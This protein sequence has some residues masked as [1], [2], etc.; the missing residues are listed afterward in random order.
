MHRQIAGKLTGRVTKWLVLA[1]WVIVVA[2]AGPL[3][4]KLTDVQD[5]QASSWLPASAESTK[6][7][8]KLAPFQDQN[9]IPTVVVYHKASGLTRADLTTIGTQLDQIQQIDG[10]IPAKAPDGTPVQPSQTV[11]V[12]QDG[13]VA[14]GMVTFNFGKDGWN[15]LPDVKDQIT[16]IATLD[17]ADVYVAGPGGQAADSAAVFAGIDGKLLY[18]TVIVV[19]VILLLTYRSPLLW[20]LPVISAGVA[21]TTAQ[22]VIYLLAKNAGLTVNG[23]SAGILTVLVF[24]AGT[25]Y[26]L[27]LVARYR[28]ELHRHQDRHEAM[29]FALHRATP[30]IIASGLTVILGM[31]CLT[32]ADM[33]STAGLGPV[34]AIG[35]GVGL[36][37]MITLL[38]ALLVIFGRWIFWPRRP[39]FDTLEPSA[40]G[41]WARVGTRIAPRPR[42]VW[43]IT[44]LVLAACSLGFL[45]LNAHGLS[46]ADSYT[47]DFDSVTGQQ[48][49]IEHGLADTSTPVQIVANSDQAAAVT[50]SLQGID[51]LGQAAPPF[52]KSGVALIS[53]PLTDDPTSK[54]AFAT[55]DEVRTAVHAV[56]GADALVGG[57]SAINADIEKASMRDNKVI[58]PLV[59]VVVMIVLM[60]LL[61]ALVSPLLLIATVV[62]SYG[63]AM[64]LS[65]LLF[66][67]LFGFAGADASLP[68]FV[69]VF[70]VALGI[71]YNIFLMTRVREE[72]PEHGTRR[73]SLIAL[74][75]TG[76]VITSAGLVLAATFLVLATLPLV[77]FAEIGFAVALGV[78]LDTLIVRSVLVTAINLD[79]GHR[80][81][82][83]SELDRA[84]V[85]VTPA[86]AAEEAEA[87]DA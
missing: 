65:A 5:N 11:Q 49:L 64:G 52:V 39:M 71:D 7:L 50:Q 58:I 41:F 33:N 22:A 51:G 29:A 14:Q 24:G 31:L 62:L 10:A 4:G 84:G 37:V 63:A 72:T 30:A 79:A 3:A 23:Q 34:A 15:K 48:V 74:G 69:F 70:L 26:A 27:L 46:T 59:L 66:R 87:L 9:D 67:N 47:K 21:L 54:A 61:R 17:G 19:V 32:F 43:V 76:G 81:W 68:L 57:G 53:V 75:A 18:A 12:S 55:V 16:S 44:S 73:A 78:L 38:P 85:E 1:F 40:T 83:P 80:I 25:D 2:A 82:W 28:E 42:M 8:A 35:I 13:Q 36:L 45:Q 77:A 6:A 20:L 56:P 86:Q 60:V